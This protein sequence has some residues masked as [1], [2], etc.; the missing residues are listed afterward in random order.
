ML[1][2]L[3]HSFADCTHAEAKE[4]VTQLARSHGFTARDRC[5]ST[6]PLPI[7]YHVRTTTIFQFSSQLQGR[8]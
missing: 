5:S 1:Q 7:L 3:I 4:V 2:Q 8:F 6:S